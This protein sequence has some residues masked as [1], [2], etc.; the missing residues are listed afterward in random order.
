[1]L[2][3]L[4]RS[5]RSIRKYQDKPVEKEKIDILLEA[6]L[7]SPSSRG[8]NPWQFI[9]IDDREL[10][11]KLSRSKA[12]GSS[13][14]KNAPLGIIVCADDSVDTWIEDC[15]IAS[16]FIKLTAESLDLKSCWIQIRDRSHSD[17][18][19]ARDYIADLVNLR[20]DLNVLSIIALGYPDDVREPH[21]PEDLRYKKI[22]LNTYGNPYTE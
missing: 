3:E 17:S 15:S 12:H 13:F 16:T 9:V 21:K 11:D 6:A 7:R 8:Y 18:V 19:T 22:S 5:R 14:L 1:M 20:E 2:I 4:I 10:L